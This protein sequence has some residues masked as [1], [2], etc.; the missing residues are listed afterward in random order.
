MWNGIFPQKA[1]EP[2][3]Q[4]LTNKYK[5]QN[6]EKKKDCAYTFGS[7]FAELTEKCDNNSTFLQRKLK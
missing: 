4:F 5:A 7:N 1:N 6:P 2:E 3:T